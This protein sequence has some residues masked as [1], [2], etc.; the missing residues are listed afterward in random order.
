LDPLFHYMISLTGGYIILK[1]LNQ[2]N[3]RALLILS[4]ISLMIDLDHFT[5]LG[6]QVLHNLT[7]PALTIVAFIYLHKKKQ[8][9]YAA[10][11]LALTVML[12]GCLLMD[13][14]QGMYGIPLFY[15]L[16][17]ELYLMP[18]SWDI[19]LP[20]DHTSN[21][22]SRHGIALLLYYGAVFLASKLFSCRR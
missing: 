2:Y 6:I 5:G 8:E 18:A 16:S 4:T 17:S 21:I 7:V 3:T 22:I 19:T 20:W 11:M 1:N 14:V 9:K 15:P 13:M 10:Y 12:G